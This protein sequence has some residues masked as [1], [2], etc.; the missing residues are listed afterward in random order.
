MMLLLQLRLLG[1]VAHKRPEQS[2]CFSTKATL[3]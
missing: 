2:F 1:R 3:F